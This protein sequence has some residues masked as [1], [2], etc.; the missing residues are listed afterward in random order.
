MRATAFAAMWAVAVATL[1]AG[2]FQA[3][4]VT[5]TSLA[6]GATLQAGIKRILPSVVQVYAVRTVQEDEE[7][8]AILRSM[9]AVPAQPEKPPL[10][11]WRQ[12]QSLGCG[13][14]ISSNGYILSNF[15]VVEGAQSIEVALTNGADRLKATV[16]GTDPATDLAVIKIDAA[17]LRPATFADSDKLDIGDICLAV[18]NPFGVGQTVTMGIVSATGRGD[19]GLTDYEDF[20]QTD[21][22]IN[23]GNSGGALVN[24]AGEVIGINTAVMATIRG[25]QGLGFAVPSNLARQVMDELIRSG[26]VERGS[27]GVSVQPLTPD[28]ARVLKLPENR[29]ALVCDVASNG[30]ACRAGLQPGDDIIACNG[31][32][33]SGPQQLHLLMGRLPPGAKASLEIIHDGKNETVSVAL[34][35]PPSPEPSPAA[36]PRL[37]HDADLLTGVTVADL[38][39][40]SRQVFKVPAQ[41]Q[42][43][44]VAAVDYD[45]LAYAAGVR[46]GD[47]IVEMDRK[48]IRD[49][50]QAMFLSRA[51]KGDELLLRVCSDGKDRFVLLNGANRITQQPLASCAQ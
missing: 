6:P 7:L 14:V 9:P 44:L 18:G 22:A 31:Q 19:L 40:A 47:V 1:V 27:L 11:Q 29:G 13:V 25:G 49:S 3:E 8:A 39:A 37:P 10:P 33:V 15:H 17:G 20:I 43:A 46:P 5:E 16:T 35:E 30:A 4:A 32:A 26:R 42:G 24:T 2:P 36:P 41:A 38:D 28:L 48:P 12:E 34:G 50:A 23:P 45:S 21:A 51:I